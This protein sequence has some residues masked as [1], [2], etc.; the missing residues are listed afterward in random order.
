VSAKS[1]TARRRRRLLLACVLAC[2]LLALVLALELPGGATPTASGQTAQQPEHF[3]TDDSLPATEVLMFGSSPGEAP[4][5]TWGIGKAQQSPARYTIVRYATGEGWTRAPAIQDAAGQPLEGFEPAGGVL[6]GQMASDGAGVLAGRASEKARVLLVRNPGQAFAETANQP[7]PEEGEE[8]VLKKG[9]ELFNGKAPLVTAL[10]E[11]AFA[12]ALAVPV[13]NGEVASPAPAVLHWEGKAQ[14]WTREPVELPAGANVGEFQAIAIAG[15][16][17]ANVW[18]LAHVYNSEDVSLFR[19]QPATEGVPASWKPVSPG[20]GQPAGSALQ[21][22]GVDITDSGQPSGQ[23]LTV[24]EQGLWVDG[25]RSSNT[26]TIFFRPSSGEADAGKVTASWCN[27]EGCSYTLPEPE[28]LPDGEYRSFAWAGGGEYGERVITGYPDDTIV[29]LR[30]ETFEREATIGDPGAPYEVGGAKGAAFSSASE[31]WLGNEQLAVH[32]TREEADDQLEYWPAPFHKPLLAIAAQPGQPVGS[33]GSEALAVGERGEVARFVPKI[34]W[35]PESLFEPSGR[36]AEPQLR[37]VAWPTPNRAYAIGARGEQYGVIGEMWLWRGETGLW[38]PDP[39]AP[40]DLRANLLGIAFDPNDAARGY[41]VGQ[42]ATLLRYGKTWTQEPTCAGGETGQCIPA[43]AAGASF[44]SVAFAGSE[45]L[46]AFRVP[47]LEEGGVLAYTGGVLANDGSGWHIDAQAAAALP[48]GYVPWAVAGLPDGGAALSASVPGGLQEPLV[49][50]RGAPGAAWQATPPYPGYT[51]PASLTLFREGGALRAVGSGA[52]PDT[53]G[54]DN[55]TPP[56]AGFPPNFPEP[57]GLGLATGVVRQTASG[58]SDQE[59]ER[60]VLSPP[61]GGYTH[62]DTP[63]TPDPTAAVL[64]DESGTDGWAVGGEVHPKE[65][66]ETA[67]IARYP[68]SPGE[69]FGSGASEVPLPAEGSGEEEARRQPHATFA[70]GGNAQCASPCSEDAN[71]KIGPDRWLETALAQAFKARG[72]RDFLYTGTHVTTGAAQHPTAIPYSLEL[73][74]YAQVLGQGDGLAEAL[75]HEQLAG[76]TVHTYAAASSTDYER[77]GSECLF[78]RDMRAFLGGLEDEAGCAGGA[79]A[80]YSFVSTGQPNVRVIVLDDGHGVEAGQLGWLQGQL[81]AAREAS[82]KGTPEPALV[83]GNVNLAEA[84]AKHELWASEVT[85]ALLAGGASAYLFDAPEQNTRVRLGEA[86]GQ[87]IYELGSGTLGYANALNAEQSDFI[88]ASGFLLVEIGQPGAQNVAHVSARL[89]PNIEELSLDAHKGALLRRSEAAMF[90]ALARRPRA[91]ALATGTSS[92]SESASFVPIPSNCQGADCQEAMFPEY[93]FHSSNPEIGAF[94]EQNV[95]AGVAAEQP[96]LGGSKE[97]PIVD[98]QSGLFCAYN[99]GTTTVT[100]EAGGIS[101]SMP[102]TVQPGSV[103]RPC[104][105]VPANKVPTPTTEKTVAAP[106]PSSSPSGSPASSP[107]VPVP[108]PPAPAVVAPPVA[109]VHPT[110]PPPQFLTPLAPAVPLAAIVPPPLA[111]A[112]EPTPPSGTSAVSAQAV[113]REEEEEEATESVSARA[114]AYRQTEHEPS[115]AYLLG[116]IVLAAFAGANIRRR[117]RRG[118]RELR[119]APATL[120]TMRS[121]RRMRPPR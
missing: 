50:E 20:E 47:H 75:D 5:E 71:A 121:Q 77:N 17:P 31:G 66:A 118:E 14:R 111:P 65:G 8:A 48:Q 15:S 80:Y 32:A 16:S 94:V 104:G 9:E 105:T 55:Q 2:P 91:G 46:V 51:A 12:G 30:G 110:P 109:R 3:F 38:E 100:V 63:Y 52:I 56:P 49:L 45:A 21:A 107:P 108:P 34:G 67:D 62:W 89:I 40:I 10:E 53:I 79:S 112:A 69:K 99:A 106:L 26:A 113:E 28:E 120:S 84:E 87:S 23:V 25:M 60:H 98:S 117:T 102:V 59:H 116:L 82:A 86:G 103:R 74:R 22:A 18:L 24:T 73:E 101:A 6:G 37:G 70:V 29:R 97:E 93:R 83:V 57:Y 44:T 115:P 42:E 92:Q 11:G 54:A 13:E 19:R 43:E 35:Q 88:G 114:S 78:E 36:R 58:W 33:I 95:R 81:S 7:E 64:L 85:A 72:L 90:S 1:I 76:A 96:E 4:N 41:V 61:S 68:A 119:V 39:A 27:V